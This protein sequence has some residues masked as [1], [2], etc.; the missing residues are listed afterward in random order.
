MCVFVQLSEKVLIE[1]LLFYLTNLF[2]DHF[3]PYQT[4]YMF[5][6]TPYPY[7]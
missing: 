7:L 4:Q 6:H 5:L 1:G 2:P 3:Y